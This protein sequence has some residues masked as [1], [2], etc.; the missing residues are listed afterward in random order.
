MRDAHRLGVAGGLIHL[1][2]SSAA[3][4]GEVPARAELDALLVVARTWNNAVA[5]ISGLLLYQNGSF[6]QILEG[7][8]GS[9]WRRSSGRYPA[10]SGNDRI[11]KIV[12]EAIANRDFGEWKMGFPNVSPLELATIPGLK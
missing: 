1:V 4:A 9:A 12:V 2:Y 5:G 11:T 7:E 10:I 6:F 3:T 8:R